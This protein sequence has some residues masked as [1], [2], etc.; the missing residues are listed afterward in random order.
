M[1]NYELF[2]KQALFFRAVL[3]SQQNWMEGT[4]ISHKLPASTQAYPPLLSISPARIAYLIYNPLLHKV[5]EAQR[6]LS[7][8][9]L[10]P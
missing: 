6:L 5:F 10:Y 1:A 8:Y 7:S 4:E 9:I 2:K 3:V